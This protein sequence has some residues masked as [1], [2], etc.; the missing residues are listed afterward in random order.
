MHVCMAGYA[1]TVS[2][3]TRYNIHADT[4]VHVYAYVKST[5]ALFYT[6]MYMYM[7][8]CLYIHQHYMFCSS[9][10]LWVVWTRWLK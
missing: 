10:A 4:L 1:V 3:V 2:A 7:Y 9:T 5:S 8:M 6:Y